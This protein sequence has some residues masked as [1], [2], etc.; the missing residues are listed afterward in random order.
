MA[1]EESDL[2]EEVDVVDM[3]VTVVTEGAEISTVAVGT[4]LLDADHALDLQTEG[5][6]KKTATGRVMNAI[7]AT[8]PGE[9]NVTGVKRPNLV[10]EAVVD[11][12]ETGEAMIEED[13]TGETETGV[14]T[15]VMIVEETGGTTGVEGTTGGVVME[16]AVVAVG[17]AMYGMVIGPVPN[18]ASTTSPVG[19]NA[20]NAMPRN[21]LS[22]C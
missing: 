16:G 8:L 7:T 21:K 20:S 13:M 15:D 11:M 5:V 9:L 2:V 19:Q 1:E 17:A 22:V 14:T 4:D 6:D 18:V 10:V 3:E 12:E